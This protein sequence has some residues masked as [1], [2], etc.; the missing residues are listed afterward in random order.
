LTLTVETNSGKAILNR[1]VRMTAPTSSHATVRD[2]KIV[3][4]PIFLLAMVK[5]C[6]MG[7]RGTFNRFEGLWIGFHRLVDGDVMLDGPLLSRCDAE[8]RRKPAV[9]AG[10]GDAIVFRG[11]DKVTDRWSWDRLRALVSGC[12]RPCVRKASARATASLR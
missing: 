5:N 1:A 7:V 6:L 4:H 8:L 10:A 12:S 11:E 2:R 3:C 9:A